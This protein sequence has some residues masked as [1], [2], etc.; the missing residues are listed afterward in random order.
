MHPK[1]LQS[2]D[3]QYFETM[4]WTTA[5]PG[6]VRTQ[7][8]MAARY[9]TPHLSHR[10]VLGFKASPSQVFTFVE[11][12]THAARNDGVHALTI[13]THGRDVQGV[14]EALRA[15]GYSEDPYPIL[16]MFIP[17]RMLF[18]NAIQQIATSNFVVRE[19]TRPEQMDDYLPIW[20]ECFP[21]QDQSRYVNDYKALLRA[22]AIGVRFFAAYD[23]DVAVSSGYMFHQPHYPMALL[24]GGATREAWRKRGAYFSLIA[25]RAQISMEAGVE[26]LCVDASPDSRPI[27]ERLGFVAN[28]DVIFFEKSFNE[29]ALRSQA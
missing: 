20:Q 19:L 3:A 18:N 17:A 7:T 25:K 24:C 14:R 16:Q 9:T 28:D 29:N 26:T 8:A 6:M 4:R 12:E 1:T 11:E 27:L 5:V 15:A 23:A 13:R 2:L 21:G 22:G 10:Y